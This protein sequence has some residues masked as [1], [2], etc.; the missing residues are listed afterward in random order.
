MENLENIIAESTELAAKWQQRADQILSSKEKT[1]QKRF[2]R[3]LKH[4][5]DK[6]VLTKIID[7]CFRSV[8]TGRVAGRIRSLFQRYGI[9]HFFLR[10]E[11]LLIRFFLLFGRFFH[12]ISIPVMIKTIIKECGRFILPGEKEA[13]LVILQERRT[14]SVKM[15]INH[16]GEAV[17]GE[18]EALRQLNRYIEDLKRP[19]VEHI[20]VKISSLYSQ[21]QP[22]A[23]ENSVAVIKDRLSILYR[24]AQE[25]PFVE[26]NGTG[27]PKFV[28]LDMEGYSDLEI[29][30]T[31]FMQALDEAGFESCQAGIALQSY[32]PQ[33]F[34]IQQRLTK[35]ARQRTANGGGP[36]KIRIVKGANLEMEKIESDI[37]NWPMAPYDNK[38][39]VDANFKRMLEFGMRP[40]NITSVYLGIASHNLFE[41]AFAYI[42]SSQRR[43]GEYVVF[44]MLEGMAPHVMRAIQETTGKILMYAP[45]ASKARFINAVAYLIRRLD[46]NTAEENFLRYACNL[47]TDSPEWS[48]L[49]QQFIDSCH[50]IHNPEMVS[51]RCQDRRDETFNEK[52]GTFFENEFVNEPDT[53]WSLPGN[54][55]WAGSIRNKWR[56]FS[57]DEPL[58]IPITVGGIDIFENRQKIESIDP[59][60][61][62]A[63][64]NEKVCVAVCALAGKEDIDSAATIA[65]ADPDQWRKMS[66]DE[67]HA[68]LSRVAVNLRRSRGDLIGAAAA[69]TGKVFSEADVEVSEAIDFVEYYPYSLKA[70]AGLNN[71]ECRGKGVGLVISPWNFPIAIPCGGI[72]A[73]LVAGN[74]VIFKPASAAIVPA[75]ELCRCFWAAGVSKNVLQFL[76]CLGS[77]AG[78]KLVAHP[79]IDFIIFTGGTDTALQILRD[80]P[81]IYFAG[82]T[83]GKNATIVTALSDRD[84]AIKNVIHSAFSNCGQKCSAT[85]LLILEK[86]VYADKNF[87]KQLVDA[88]Q[89]YATGSAWNFKNRM[90]PLIQPPAGKLKKG[91]N[92]LSK[93]EEWALQP[94]NIHGNPNLWTPGIKWG[95][96]PGSY[97]HLTEFFG[98]LLGV[99]RAKN[100]DDAVDITNQTGYGLT[101]GL[102]SLDYEEQKYWKKRIKA[103]NLYINRGTTGAVVLRQPFGGMGKSALGAGIKAGG[104]N[105]VMQFMEIRDVS[106]PL[107]GA[108]ADDHPLLQLTRFWRQKL[109]RGGL[110]EY[111]TDLYKTLSAVKSYLYAKEAEFSVEKDYF[112][113]RGQDNLLR[114][115]PLGKMA[116]RLHGKDSLFEIL[117]R[118]AAVKI[119]GCSLIISIP[120]GLKNGSVEILS[121]KDGKDFIGSPE[122]LYQSDKDLIDMLPEV[123]GIRYAAPERVPPALLKAAA[124][125][126]FYISGT[127]VVMEGRIE[128]LQYHPEQSICCNYH[129]YGNLGERGVNYDKK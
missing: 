2:Q 81:E 50:W 93:G 12:R 88:A 49:K 116:V 92:H 55:E 95:V 101:S 74:T 111:K 83:G 67:R 44:E 72:T 69:N 117:A 106:P 103:G 127:K 100:L 80:R 58:E 112:H 113:L 118:I 42:L 110:K 20:S 46:E 18:D 45:V 54:H 109:N 22:F 124:R 91:L 41:L 28:N 7:Q 31:A 129:R 64:L 53:D 65:K 23:F 39:D 57:G 76:P 78:A 62:R 75:W 61:I 71:I 6:V 79:E 51:H 122:I 47:K 40:E 30:V 60:S 104:P 82:E 26:S 121:G 19:E 11:R 90:G 37:S 63:D 70:L 77:A 1:Y 73:A 115:L 98:P 21:I 34:E 125:R 33:G 14:S 13:L 8:N 48:F 35:W 66:P 32:L 99:M 114:Y 119:S 16:I 94:E 96:Q 107:T 120:E 85:S 97:T 10:R 108:V 84:Q 3:L 36:I 4:S 9:P 128:L 105:Y 59:S 29:T 89:S 15:N 25:N 86:E 52:K 5:I 38:L 68:I 24:T 17:L 43:I 27:R 123:D 126:G 56:K 102:E 87:K